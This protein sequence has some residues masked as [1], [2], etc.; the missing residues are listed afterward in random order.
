ME[1]LANKQRTELV[2]ETIRKNWATLQSYDNIVST[3]AGL[4]TKNGEYTDEICIVIAVEKK[5]PENELNASRIFPATIDNIG[6]DITEKR[7]FRPA[8]LQIPADEM[9]NR[10]RYRPLLGGCL[11]TNGRIGPNGMA[12]AGTLGCLVYIGA[13]KKKNAYTALLS[14]YHVMYD[15]G[16]TTNTGIGQPDILPS[17]YVGRIITGSKVGTEL[18]FAI[19]KLDDNIPIKNEVIE[20]GTLKGFADAY[21]TQQVRKYGFKT[22]LTKGTVTKVNVIIVGEF[23]V[24]V[25]TGVEITG[26]NPPFADEGDSGSVVVDYNNKVIG[27]L[28]GVQVA[29]EN[30]G[31]ANDQRMLL[32]VEP[33]VQIP[34]PDT[35]QMQEIFSDQPRLDSYKTLMQRSS[36]SRQLYNDFT[37]HLEETVRLVNED[38]ESMVAWQRLQGPSFISIIKN[39]DIRL[40]YRF[41]RSIKGISVE[42]MV[43]GMA[44]VF[45]KR[46]SPSLAAAIEKH[47]PVIA[48]AV[49]GSETVEEMIA[50]FTSRKE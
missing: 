35:Y 11:I 15:N 5:K 34:V 38:R 17:N 45:K 3:G 27:L 25:Y 33:N 50:V 46:G 40:P 1:N 37:R 44:A 8:I 47:A 12:S 20:I 36:Y 41:E 7:E 22:L 19:A 18:D 4:R 26:L 30:I 49:A 10:E 29:N 14:N 2:I 28:W 13:S 23:P 16:G 24:T 31:I 6:I 32:S 39:L 9:A 43:T 48:A 42:D 21:V